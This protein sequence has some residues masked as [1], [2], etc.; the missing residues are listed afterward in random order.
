MQNVG[1]NSKSTKKKKKHPTCGR[2]IW[3]ELFL[4]LLASQPITHKQGGLKLSSFNPL[5]GACPSLF[6]AGEMRQN[7]LS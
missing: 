1:S 7:R 4:L 2:V 6:L 5:T 3:V